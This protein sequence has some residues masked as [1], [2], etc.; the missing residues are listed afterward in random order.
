MPN[1]DIQG[2]PSKAGESTLLFKRRSH[3]P[4]RDS[5]ARHEHTIKREWAGVASP[6][7]HETEHG[8]QGANNGGQSA[9]NGPTMMQRWLR[10][11]ERDQPYNN[12]GSFF[13]KYDKEQKK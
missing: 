7:R 12:I 10:E 3:E 5:K 8:T 11:G 6:I 4:S 9:P 13:T 1:R 2:S